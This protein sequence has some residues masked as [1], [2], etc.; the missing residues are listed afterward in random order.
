[1]ASLVAFLLMLVSAVW[2]NVSMAGSYTGAL[3]GAI[4]AAGLSLLLLAFAVR[5]LPWPGRVMLV[6]VALV[7]GYVLLDAIG[8]LAGMRVW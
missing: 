3:T 6:P 4:V 8:R 2:D 1:M 7:D 5:Q